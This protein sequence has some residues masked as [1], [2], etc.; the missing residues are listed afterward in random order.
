MKE[1]DLPENENE[2]LK[3]LESY[4]ILDTLE[5]KS[6]DNITLIASQICDTPISLVSLV[7]DERQWFK[8][9]HGLEATETPREYAF[10][11]HAII[12]PDVVFSIEDSRL[13][14]R[15]KDNPLVTGD[16]R[17]I[18]YTGVPLVN[19]DGNALGTLCVID[20]T[21]RTLDVKQVK[22]LKALGNQVVKLLELR[23]TNNKLEEINAKLSEFAE[24]VE[25]ELESPLSE[26]TTF[27][28]LMI[29]SYENHLDQKGKDV[30]RGIDRNAVRLKRIIQE[31]LWNIR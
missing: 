4:Q 19:P 28:A 15:F 9:H 8:S 22:A 1:A 18:F 16:P 27:T 14:D 23:K 6:Y 21:P 31:L 24:E 26:L 10:C 3:A 2:R 5:E 11:A 12:E 25:D 13:D 20:N 29:S 7:D 17:V 30:L